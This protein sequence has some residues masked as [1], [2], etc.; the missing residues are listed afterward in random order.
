MIFKSQHN[1]YFL[2]DISYS[3]LIFYKKFICVQ[4]II[5]VQQKNLPYYCAHKAIIWKVSSVNKSENI[6]FKSSSNVVVG[7]RRRFLIRYSKNIQSMW[8]SIFGR[9]R[10]INCTV[11]RSNIPHIKLWQL[12]LS[13]DS[14]LTNFSTYRNEIKQTLLSSF[15]FIPIK[16]ESILFNFDWKFNF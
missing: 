3:F 10:I 6:L 15:F 1:V 13:D 16:D 7:L 2:Y 11:F 12:S 9:I 4:A 8:W 5:A 14:I